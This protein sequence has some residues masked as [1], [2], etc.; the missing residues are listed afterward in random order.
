MRYQVF[1]IDPV[2][3]P[4]QTHSARWKK[5][6]ADE[7]YYRFK[8][9][10]KLLNAS[11]PESGWHVLF[12]IKMPLSWTEKKKKAYDHMP[13]QQTPDKDNLEKALLDA[14][15]TDDKHIWDGRISKVW[16]REGRIVLITGLENGWIYDFLVEI[17][18]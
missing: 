5:T 6:P 13:H 2:A 15:F 7:K 3:K 1:E 14:C 8:D 4:R 12:V 11:V 10:I 18:V 17:E 9:E 16:G